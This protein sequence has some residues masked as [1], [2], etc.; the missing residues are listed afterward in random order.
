M[1]PQGSKW[2]CSHV[3]AVQVTD[4]SHGLESDV[5]GSS[6]L[7]M[8]IGGSTILGSWGQSCSHSSAR[9]SP[10]KALFSVTTP[11]AIF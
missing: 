6:R 4:S 1:G 10:E 8:H 7:E 11:V 9:Q 5:C 3:F 2:P